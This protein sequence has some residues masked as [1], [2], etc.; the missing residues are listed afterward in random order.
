MNNNSYIVA[1]QILDVNMSGFI[2]NLWEAE[3]MW[4]QSELHIA[5]LLGYMWLTSFMCIMQL[6]LRLRLAVK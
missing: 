2:L 5:D 1:K 6:Y 4:L 3:H